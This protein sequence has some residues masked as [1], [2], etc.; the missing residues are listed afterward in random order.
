M[1]PELGTFALVLA[2]IVALVQSSLPMIGAAYGNAAWI[3]LARPAAQGQF[4][5]VALAFAC[6]T[7]SFVTS[8][9]SVLYVA[10]NSN[11][12]LPTIYKV[13]AVWGGHE[14]S[15]LLWILILAVSRWIRFSRVMC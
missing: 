5:F 15:A 8:D 10:S 9:F 13:T 7:Y 3:A 2:L 14:G 12:L 4:T 6:L 1:I 11:T